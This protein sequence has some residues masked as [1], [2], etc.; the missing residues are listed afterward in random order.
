[1]INFDHAAAAEVLPEVKKAYPQLLEQYS[2]NPEAAHSRG[3]ELR[4]QIKNLEAELW[5]ALLPQQPDMYGAVFADSATT[6]INAVGAVFAVG[7]V[8]KHRYHA[9]DL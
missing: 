4:N 9:A 7:G 2:G 1:M 3:H 6:L 5:R 8:W